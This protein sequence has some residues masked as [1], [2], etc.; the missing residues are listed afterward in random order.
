M[1]PQHFL[2]NILKGYSIGIIMLFVGCLIIT[3]GE[4]FEP[5]ILKIILDDTA[6]QTSKELI[7]WFL[8][9][10]VIKAFVVLGWYCISKSHLILDTDFWFKNIY[11]LIGFVFK[12]PQNIFRTH[13]IGGFLNKIDDIAY[14]IPQVIKLIAEQFWRLLI[15]MVVMV[16]LLCSVNGWIL[17][18]CFGW[19]FIFLFLCFLGIKYGKNMS[20]VAAEGRSNLFADISDILDN[21]L[22]IRLFSQEKEEMKRFQK[23]GGISVS[24]YRIR[25]IFWLKWYLVQ[26]IIYWV[27]SS[28]LIALLAYFKFT[29]KISNG[30]FAMVIL[31]NLKVTDR[32]FCFAHHLQDLIDY[33]GRI[34]QGLTFVQYA[35]SESFSN[36]PLLQVSKGEITFEHITF[37]YDESQMLFQDLSITI[38]AGEKVGLV[39]FSGAGKSSFIQLL[40]R[41]YDPYSGKI[42]IDHQDIAFCDLRSLRQSIGMIPQDINLFKRTLWENIVYGLENVNL[43][44]V[45]NVMKDIN[46]YSWIMSLPEQY[47]T[48][49]GPGGISLSG[50]QKQRIAWAR[51]LLKNPPIIL[52][53]EGTSQIDS[54]TESDIQKVF[55]KFIINRTV[56]VIAHKL[57]AVQNMDRILVFSEGKIVEEGNH[58]TLL[59]NGSV[60][61]QLWRFNNEKKN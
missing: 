35:S 42:F 11:T 9:W 14:V 37:G 18:L 25:D 33:M 5:Y 17:I 13:P 22:T 53:D 59:A 39:G 38:H 44:H 48:P 52:I 10:G 6:I 41:L 61:S 19:I 23:I 12:F 55:T 26:D 34:V 3:L 51:V 46:L 28:C 58:E 43:E 7:K 8:I 4:N 40:V 50:G 15:T 47:Q 2:K 16:I 21:F 29:G 45:D 24:H 60:Y 30:D 27:Y 57:H 1:K 56:L 32:L 49:L 36:F 54:I 20:Q 31:M